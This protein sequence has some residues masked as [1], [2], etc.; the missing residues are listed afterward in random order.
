MKMSYKQKTFLVDMIISW[1]LY[2]ILFSVLGLLLPDSIF[3]NF[4]MTVAISF[5]VS[6]IMVLIIINFTPLNKNLISIMGELE[7]NGYTDRFFMLSEQE[8]QRLISAGRVYKDYRF[9]CQYIVYQADGYMLLGNINAALDTL[10]RI[11]L[12]DMQSFLKKMDNNTFLIYFDLQMCLS[13]E[14]NDPARANAVMQDAASFIESAL[15]KGI[16]PDLLIFETYA[17]Y[18]LVTGDTAKA[19]EY[20]ERCIKRENIPLCA[21]EGNAI[22]A[23][24]CIKTGRFEE[25]DQY[26]AKIE[27]NAGTAALQKQVASILRGKLNA[28]QNRG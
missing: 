3:H 20:A 7:K 26:I 18:Y 2:V 23:K 16:Y 19:E 10:N 11:N 17:V 4:W 24:I 9:F 21:Y 1:P 27:Q 13:E 6:L 14:L 28:A 15:G 22:H 5:V 12:K 25:A 8:I